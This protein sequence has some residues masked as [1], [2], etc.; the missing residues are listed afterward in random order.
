MGE[1]K[2]DTDVGKHKDFMVVEDHRPSSILKNTEEMQAIEGWYHCGRSNV[3]EYVE[4]D[5][6]SAKE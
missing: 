4:E 1:Q 2:E 6:G 3:W 5:S